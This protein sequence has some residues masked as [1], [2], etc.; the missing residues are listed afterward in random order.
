MYH[1]SSTKYE[2]AASE[3]A[4]KGRDKMEAMIAKG[5]STAMA[6]VE[7]VQAQ[8]PQDSL[9]RTQ[10]I[11]IQPIKGGDGAYFGSGYSLSAI[12]WAP[13]MLHTLA[14]RQ[15]ADKTDMPNKYLDILTARGDWGRELA[16]DNFNRLLMHAK[17]NDKNLIRKVSTKDGLE[18]RGVL[19]D[20]FRRIDSRPL[21]DA[22][23][24]ACQSLDAVPIEGYALET[25]VRMRAVL[26]FVFEPVPNEV[27]L[28][29]I[30]WG[31]SDFGD[32]GHC[33]S[34]FNIR[35]WCTNTA[36]MDEVL[37]QVH[38]GR[39]ISEDIS[40]STQTL[41]LDTQ[42]NA[43]AMK[44]VVK[45]FLGPKRVNGYLDSIKMACE[46][47]IEEKDVLRLLKGKLGKEET[48]RVSDLFASPD[49]QNLPP[50]NTS[51][52]LSN[53]VSWFAQ[54]AS[55]SRGRQ[56]DLQRL[57]GELLPSMTKIKAREV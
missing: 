26:P 15:L 2:V 39:T 13:A 24:G 11:H 43:S 16:A 53:A 54:D 30:Q 36:V 31:N 14:L 21:L 45:E 20:R 23:I 22:F 12:D 41:N 44:D 56:L 8:V 42:A 52:R 49:V 32:G 46:E 9:V 25:K 55:V 10:G 3:A 18:V 35:V 34:L 51:Y 40:Y 1:H 4:K 50:G 19:S 33:L 27:M 17:Q 57:A 37:R 7:Q 28:F 48:Q 29:G 5:K 38:L 6:V 47:N